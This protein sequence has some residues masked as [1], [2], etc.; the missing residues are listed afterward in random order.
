MKKMILALL[1]L[2]VFAMPSF[3]AQTT[4]TLTVA[5]DGTIT[6]SCSDFNLPRAFALDI[7]VDSGAIITDVTGLSGDYWVYPGSIDINTADGSVNDVGAAVCSNSYPGTL[8]G[9]GTNGVTIEM[10]SLYVGAGNAPSLPGVVCKLIVD[11]NCTATIVENTIRAGVVMET[12]SEDPTVTQSGG[13]ISLDC[14][15][16]PDYAE[17]VVVGKP[18]SW[19]NVRQCHGDADGIENEYGAPDPFTGEYNKAWVSTEDIGFI[20]AGFRKTYTGSEAW[21]AADFDH[22]NN[23][24]GAPD[25]F[26]GE[27]NKARV[28]TEDI[29]ELISYFRSS[30]VPTDCLD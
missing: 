17:W 19:C 14:Y 23:E 12:P 15:T 5:T 11:K 3:A 4:V 6:A 20:I 16:G 29:S 28:S 21:I 18:D 13:A 7:T 8:D 22:T 25:P 24:Y 1:M 10:G 9:I 2:G 26:T 27:Y 30:S